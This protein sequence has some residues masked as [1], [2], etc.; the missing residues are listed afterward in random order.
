MDDVIKVSSKSNPNSVAGAIAGVISEKGVTEIQVIGAG[1]LN[2]AIKAIAIARGF[3][4]PSGVNLVF[5]PAF[6]DIL[7]NNENKTAIK[8]IVG[9]RKKRT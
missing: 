3:V 5:V 2:Q 6:L 7:I 8:L 4:A 9:P 1:A